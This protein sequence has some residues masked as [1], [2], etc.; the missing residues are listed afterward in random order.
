MR[1]AKSN[2]ISISINN[3]PMTLIIK[4]AHITVIMYPAFRY[5]DTLMIK[6]LAFVERG[7]SFLEED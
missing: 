5:K 6:Y 4:A 1:Y 2:E 3:Q 7:Q